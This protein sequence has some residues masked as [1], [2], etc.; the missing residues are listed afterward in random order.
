MFGDMACAGSSIAPI[1]EYK[2]T[3][4]FYKALVGL[5]SVNSADAEI[6]DLQIIV[7]AVF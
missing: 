1:T 2:I 6:F 7:H 4:S 5:L 3:S